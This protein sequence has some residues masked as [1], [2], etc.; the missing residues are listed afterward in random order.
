ML[1]PDGRQFVGRLRERP[2]QV[3]R[4]DFAFVVS[5][6]SARQHELDHRVRQAPLGLHRAHR[7]HDL[8]LRQPERLHEQRQRPNRLRLRTHGRM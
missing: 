8:V 6:P 1:E 5:G 4:E 3:A 2:Q 7:R